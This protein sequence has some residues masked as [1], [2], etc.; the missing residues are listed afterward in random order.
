MYNTC[1][2]TGLLL[3]P[4]FPA[5]AATP[6]AI[7]TCDCCGKGCL[8]VKCPYSLKD[9]S[10]L[11]FEKQKSSCLMINDQGEMTLDY[12]HAYFFQIQL[13]M[14]ISKTSYCDFVVWSFNDFFVER[15]QFNEDFLF[16]HLEL[17]KQFHKK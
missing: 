13:Q 16:H 17:A 14:A 12:R 4:D 3:N 2:R 1:T 10:I 11:E 7:I 6:D 15:I 8:E 5:F 9:M